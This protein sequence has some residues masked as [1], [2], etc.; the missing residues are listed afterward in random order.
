MSPVALPCQVACPPVEIFPL[1]EKYNRSHLTVLFSIYNIFKGVLDLKGRV[2][3][4]L[5]KK[6]TALSGLFFRFLLW[7][8]TP[9]K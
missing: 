6:M 1:A 3:S 9:K 7:Q 8:K 2:L 5:Q 4:Y